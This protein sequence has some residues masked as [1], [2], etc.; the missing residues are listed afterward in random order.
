[1]NIRFSIRAFSHFTRG[2]L[3]ACL[4][5]LWVTF[6]QADANPRHVELATNI[7]RPELIGNSLTGK[8]FHPM[9]G[10]SVLGKLYQAQNYQPLWQGSEE[11]R[12]RAT[13][14][15]G[16]LP[17]VSDDGLEPREYRLPTRQTRDRVIDADY[18]I[19]MS[20]TFLAL[21]D[22]LSHG[23]TSPGEL[24]I[25]WD[26]VR[27]EDDLLA[28]AN[29]ILAADDFVAELVTSHPQHK[30]YIKL[31]T[32]LKRYRDI[33]DL[34]GWPR[35]PDDL[36]L[37]TGS[38]DSRIAL[39]RERLAIESG[40]H[41]LLAGDSTNRFD[42]HL[43]QAILNFQRQNGL[44]ADGVVGRDTLAALNITAAQRV[45][46]IALNLERWRWLPAQLGDKH[47]L[48]NSANFK[49]TL[50]E[51]ETPTL[52]MRVIVGKTYR[53][54]PIVS[55]EIKS[56]VLNPTWTV[57]PR[58]LHR[59]ILPRLERDPDY[60]KA[61]GIRIFDGWS[62]DAIQL[63]EDEVDWSR[64]SSRHTPYRVQQAAGAK[65]A[66]GRVKFMFP[67]QHSIFIHDTPGR[68]LFNER[69]RTFSSGCIR[70]ERPLALA[71]ALLSTV[72]NGSDM[73]LQ[74]VLDA[75][76]TTNLMLPRSVPVHLV[77]LTAWV[78]DNG[79]LQFRRDVYNRDAN[80]QLA[81]NNPEH[82]QV[83]TDS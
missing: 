19:A 60:L 21:V 22:D 75:G 11:A 66:L 30:H 82:G 55:K 51:K 15:A 61:R 3:V 4:L 8:P 33:D 41:R 43:E 7:D 27:G 20:E 2:V 52:D 48:V 35:M 58:I 72:E 9:S 45:E 6:S 24:G 28:T 14:L 67:N 12:R 32:A 81:V 74:A 47:I 13:E 77:Y 49:L 70:V 38:I 73:D 18:D 64:V 65:N 71:R 36:L 31:R 1:M 34:G 10:G 25:E 29:R 17:R 59:D 76:A 63:S 83:S 56:L 23:R 40:D 26:I 68:S 46:Q 78:D 53:Q 79:E 16:F 80:Q 57:P 5:T 50:Y 69:V 54:T 62:A 39:L 44:D 42:K 37:V